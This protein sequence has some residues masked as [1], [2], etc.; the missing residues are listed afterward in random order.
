MKND[1]LKFK[2]IF[3]CAVFLSGFLAWGN[4]MAADYYVAQ[5]DAGNANG[6]SCANANA[7][8]DLTWGTGN[9]VTAGDTLHLCGTITSTLTIGASGSDGSPIAIIFEDNAKFS[10]AYWGLNGAITITNKNYITIDGNDVGV[11]EATA[12][13]T[14]LANQQD[15]KGI[16]INGGSNVNVRNLTI[17]DLYVRTPDSS[18]ANKY[19]KAI[20]VQNADSVTLSNLI[21]EDAY[22]AI[23][24]YASS[25]N[26]SVLNINN[27]D[28]SRVSTGIVAAL[29]GNV[30]YSDI[31]IHD[32]RLYDFYVW[33]GCWG[34]CTLQS[35]WHHNDGI[36][37]WGNFSGNT[38]GPVYIYNNEIRGDFG[39][40]TSSFIFISDYTTPVTIYNNLIY[41]T[42]ELP[43]DGFITLGS[44]KTGAVAYVYNNTVKGAGSG[45]TGG[46]GVYLSNANGSIV[47]IKNNIF[48]NCYIG[49]YDSQ[50][51]SSIT[52]D[53]NIYYLMTA[54]GR[55]GNVYYGTLST[56]RNALGGCPNAGNE[57][58]GISADPRL[59]SSSDFSLQTDSPAINAGADLSEYFTT[60]ILGNTRSGNWDIG[61]Y[62]YTGAADTIAPAAPSGLSVQ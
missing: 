19:Q 55:L 30:N 37:T 14:E 18:D 57:C 50:G 9:N 10:A 51:E 56:W 15:G 16:Y 3:F 6:T 54:Q 33:D 58:A 23:Y 21:I 35:E 62:E 59:V 47:D 29:D 28:I 52:A 27:N 24:A 41:T 11:I 7:L 8:A 45:N 44:Y 25:A 5:T 26:K 49:L 46:N 39:E 42:A 43:K 53:N 34:S 38:V 22:Y 40:H 12:N 32:N 17:K 36:H 13:G 2:I 4:A 1:N 48:T 60:D 31:S 20:Q 61:A